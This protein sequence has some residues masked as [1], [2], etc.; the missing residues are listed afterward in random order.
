MLMLIGHGSFDG[1]DYKFN[2][3]GPDITAGETRRPV[4]SHSRRRQLIVNTTSAS[5]GSVPRWKNQG[6]G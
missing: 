1:A 5:G 3:V 4:R 2:L 6:E